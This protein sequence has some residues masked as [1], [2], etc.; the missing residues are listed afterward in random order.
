MLRGLNKGNVS[1]LGFSLALAAFGN[2][3][4]SPLNIRTCVCFYVLH[5]YKK[6]LQLEG[7]PG[8]IFLVDWEALILVCNKLQLKKSSNIASSKNYEHYS[9][10]IIMKWGWLVLSNRFVKISTSCGV[11]MVR[12]NQIVYRV[13]LVVI[14]KIGKFKMQTLIDL[15]LL[16]VWD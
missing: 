13:W 11:G 4:Y 10:T 16:S 12:S 7:I 14:Q 3:C 8:F 15:L 9:K 1:S 5:L 6:Y 2:V